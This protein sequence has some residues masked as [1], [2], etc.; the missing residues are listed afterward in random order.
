MTTTLPIN[1]KQEVIE[2]K[3][4]MKALIG[5]SSASNLSGYPLEVLLCS[6]SQTGSILS[7]DLGYYNLEYFLLTKV[8]FCII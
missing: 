8:L 4:I 5:A 6:L 3:H 2:Y 7:N 1:A